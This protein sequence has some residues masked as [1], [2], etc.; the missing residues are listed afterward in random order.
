MEYALSRRILCIET[1]NRD[2]YY[3]NPSQVELPVFP[4][5]NGIDS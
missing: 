4:V 2:N 3:F 5:N 1:K